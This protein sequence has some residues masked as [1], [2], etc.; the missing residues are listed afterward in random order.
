V[1]RGGHR[2]AVASAQA[3]TGGGDSPLERVTFDLALS[4]GERLAIV[5][6]AIH[7]LP[8]IRARGGAAMRFEFAACRI[9]AGPGASRA[10]AGW[11]EAGGL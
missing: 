8:V 6:E 7:R 3:V 4:D 10:P 9:G 1:C 5:T 11:L 2:V